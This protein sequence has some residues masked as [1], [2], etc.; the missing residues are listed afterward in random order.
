M[1]TVKLKPFGGLNTYEVPENI[2]DDQCQKLNNY[3]YNNGALTMRPALRYVSMN[4]C[5][6]ILDYYPKDGT[7]TL[8]QEV[9]NSDGSKISHYGVIL[10][11]KTA[12]IGLSNDGETIIEF[13][14]SPHNSGI[15]V[16][17]G[18]ANI[19]ITYAHFLP[20]PMINVRYASFLII[21][22]LTIYKTVCLVNSQIPQAFIYDLA[23]INSTSSV[24]NNAPYVPTIYINSPP[25]GG[26]DAFEERNLLN[27]FVKQQF[28][29]AGYKAGTTQVELTTVEGAVT[30][31]GNAKI[32]VTARGMNGSPKTVYFAVTTVNPTAPDVAAAGISALKLDADVSAFF[33]VSGTD[34]DIILTAKTKAANDYTINIAIDNDTCSG[35][36]ALP[37]SIDLV[38]GEAPNNN[39][40]YK[41]IDSSIDNEIVVIDYYKLSTGATI[42]GIILPFIE[43]FTTK[44]CEIDGIT[45]TLD[46][47]NGKFTLASAFEDADLYNAENN[48]T[49]TYSKTVTG[50]LQKILGST[51]FA[52]FGGDVQGEES[53]NRVFLSGNPSYPATVFW[54]AVNNPLYFPLGNQTSVGQSF[55]AIT[56]FGKAY[57]T[58]IVFKENSTY[59]L[60]YSVQEIGGVPIF[61]IVKEVSMKYGCDMPH[62]IALINNELVWCH[63]VNGVLLLKST[64]SSVQDE[65]QVRRLSRNINSELLAVT[66]NSKPTAT[67]IDYKG[68]YYLFVGVKAFIWDYDLT[69]FSMSYKD[70][71]QKRL[72]WFIWTLPTGTAK[73]PFFP[74]FDEI[75]CADEGFLYKFDSTET[76]DDLSFN[77]STPTDIDA[78]F[79]LKNYDLGAVEVQKAL[80]QVV[81]QLKDTDELLITYDKNGTDIPI[82]Y[83][84]GDTLNAA[85]P[86]LCYQNLLTLGISGNATISDIVLRYDKGRVI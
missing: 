8:L 83:T 1:A 54:S 32:T 76:T 81:L 50:S 39:T 24:S 5:G 61:F 71:E 66:N 49:V 46:R 52:Y 23:E 80:R 19:G 41:L 68:K 48:L 37:A 13:S 14:S 27:S 12:V 60:D 73:F 59:R 17:L 43:G 75:Y 16:P 51:I 10:L 44:T 63:S 28:T 56:A 70:D 31:S 86:F 38:S 78:S 21:D 82:T 29:T 36:I 20:P 62:T 2:N 30:T 42:Q 26:G 64:M 35:L 15:I 40:I 65:R 67:A 47:E 79:K 57:D 84:T 77:E 34:A 18:V 3:Y 55:D 45:I 72:A 58:L 74:L 4:A 22:N 25:S 6:G 9:I 85:P 33:T 7:S 69:P 53:G 11:C